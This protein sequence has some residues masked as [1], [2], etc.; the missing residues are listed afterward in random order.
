[1]DEDD[2]VLIAVHGLLNVGWYTMRHVAQFIGGSV[3]SIQIDCF[4]V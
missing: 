3:Q 1:M 4:V 2:K